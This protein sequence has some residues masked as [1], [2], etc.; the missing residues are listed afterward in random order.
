MMAD[1][2]Y[3][4]RKSANTKANKSNKVS[5][6]LNCDTKSKTSLIKADLNGD[7]DFGL[8]IAAS[9][10]VNPDGEVPTRTIISSGVMDQ[11]GK[12]IFDLFFLTKKCFM[13]KMQ[14]YLS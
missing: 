3:S 2:V 11:K 14:S 9:E 8:R 7:V 1:S 5:G 13:V 10:I 6:F 12:L 4:C